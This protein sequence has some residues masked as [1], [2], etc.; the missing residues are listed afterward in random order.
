[1][2]LQSWIPQGFMGC[3]CCSFS[4][5]L[6]NKW[7]IFCNS[8]INW[9]VR[10][11]W[12]WN[13]NGHYKLVLNWKQTIFNICCYI[14]YF[15]NFRQTNND[16]TFRFFGYIEIFKMFFLNELFET[17]V[18]NDSVW[19]GLSLS[20]NRIEHWAGVRFTKVF[21]TELGHKYILVECS[22]IALCLPVVTKLSRYKLV[23]YK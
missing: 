7:N 10:I 23:C 15:I 12:P 14:W 21:R 18:K 11:Y 2:W 20:Y 8:R 5:K 6:C 3:Y 16:K 9:L 22:V 17:R 1:M 19:P 4:L 13:L